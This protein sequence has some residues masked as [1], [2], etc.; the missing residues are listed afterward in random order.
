LRPHVE[1]FAR[2]RPLEPMP[3]PEVIF[4]G[5][6]LQ[7]PSS[8]TV[9][10]NCLIARSRV[11]RAGA[12]A[13]GRRWAHHRQTLVPGTHEIGAAHRAVNGSY[14]VAMSALP[15]NACWPRSR[16]L[17][18]CRADL[19]RAQTEQL[20]QRLPVLRL[21]YRIGVVVRAA[22][23]QHEALGLSRFVEQG[24]AQCW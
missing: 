24:A 11:V 2:E 12:I 17:R 20:G 6:E 3:M 23:H 8:S 9:P 1:T 15:V 10:A 14:T 7:F 13:E 21:A 22:F 16:S 19:S 5:P 18:S 4:D